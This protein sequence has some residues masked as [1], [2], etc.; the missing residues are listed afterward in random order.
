VLGREVVPEL[1]FTTPEAARLA[2]A[3][4]Q[5]LEDPGATGAQLT[6]F[7]ELRA[8]MEQGAPGAPRAD[9]AEAV[10][11]RLGQSYRSMI[12]T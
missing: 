3:T 6:A 7:R 12:G 5:L 9:P 4:L 2:A 11:G 8:L 1:L 10:L